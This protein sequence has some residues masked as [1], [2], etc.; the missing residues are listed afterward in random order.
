MR[1]V[2][3]LLL[4]TGLVLGCSKKETSSQKEPVS[5]KEAKPAS[6]QDQKGPE[7]TWKVVSMGGNGKTTPPQQIGDMKIVIANQQ[8]TTTKA[9]SVIEQATIT[10]DPSKQPKTI[11]LAFSLGEVKGQTVLGIYEIT[12]DSLRF[13]FAE[14]GKARPTEIANRAGLR[15]DVW[16][17]R[18]E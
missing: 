9:G 15:Q 11:D 5:A 7:G 8:Y 12:G 13:A 16:E 3:T 14:P 18:R 17:L 10:I 2:L 1:L 6:Q 4:A